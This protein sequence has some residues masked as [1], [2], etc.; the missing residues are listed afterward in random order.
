MLSAEL[1]A[2]ADEYYTS[3]SRSP[4]AQQKPQFCLCVI[5][6]VGAGKSTVLRKIANHLPIIRVS[7][8]EVRKMIYEKGL[9]EVSAEI[10]AE[11]NAITVSRLVGEGYRFAYDNDFAHPDIR[12]IMLA[13]RQKS[14]VPVFWIRVSP[15]EQFIL[16]KLRAHPQP[17]HLFKSTDEAITRYYQRKELHTAQAA[18]LARLP[19]LYTFDTSAPDLDEQVAA[20][21]RIITER[22]GHPYHM[23]ES[24]IQG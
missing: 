16:N 19:Y 20:A 8:D 4:E 17:T 14:S 9:P 15:P 7:G 22:T 1:K 21:V 2:I 12:S 5:G 13:E 18:E 23:F 24:Q 10:L 3:L 6:L 11:M